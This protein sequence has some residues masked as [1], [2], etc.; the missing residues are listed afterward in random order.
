MDS[1]ADN[2]KRPLD[3][4]PVSPTL[5][6]HIVLQTSN[7][8]ALR[9]WYITVLDAH[10]VQDNG[11]LCFLTYDEE[12]HRVAIIELPGLQARDDKARG[13]HHIAY[14]YRSLGDLLATYRRLK[15]QGIEPYWPINH[16]PTVS[17]YY[18][19]PDGNS[20][21]LQVD[22]FATKQEATA[23]FTSEAFRA[24]PIGV[25]FDPEELVRQYE[26]G[27]PEQDL[28]RRPDGPPPALP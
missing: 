8:A 5:F 22:A 24:N 13:M 19:D 10:V 9:Q 27:A 14:T 3:A 23:F 7:M 4:R 15:A 17:M 26:A 21:E 25:N 28:L 11:M 1:R 12:H 16:G 6:A 18:R 20:V 2:L